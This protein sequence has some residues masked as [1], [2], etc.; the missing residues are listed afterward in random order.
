MKRKREIRRELGFTL[1]EL[2]VSIGIIVLFT[3]VL[4]PAF[5]DFGKRNELTQAGLLVQTKILE[6]KSLALAPRASPGVG[7][8]QYV[9][10]APANPSVVGCT[11]DDRYAITEVTASGTNLVVCDVMPGGIFFRPPQTSVTFGVVAQ[12]AITPPGPDIIFQIE[13]PRLTPPNNTRTITVR[14]ATAQITITAP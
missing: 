14:R 10:T 9:F 5:G 6:T 13:H 8:S 4:L 2:L 11:G 12:G 7:I 1:A 3:A